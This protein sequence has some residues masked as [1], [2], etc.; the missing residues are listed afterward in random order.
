MMVYKLGMSFSNKLLGFVCELPGKETTSSKC[1][2]CM[3][4]KHITSGLFKNLVFVYK[5]F[6]N[7]LSLTEMGIDQY[8]TKPKEH[9]LLNFRFS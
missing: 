9:S 4:V 2:F 1:V 8:W 3:Y 7:I 6:V 5:M